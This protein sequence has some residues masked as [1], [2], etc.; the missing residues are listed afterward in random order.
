MLYWDHYF[1]W[2]LFSS[3]RSLL[4]AKAT[5]I[6]LE[7]C[8]LVIF[9]IWG[10]CFYL[11]SVFFS[12]SCF[13]YFQDCDS[14]EP[15]DSSYYWPF[16]GTIIFLWCSRM[17]AWFPFSFLILI[18]IVSWFLH[19]ILCLFHWDQSVLLMNLFHSRKGFASWLDSN[20]SWLDSVISDSVEGV[21]SFS[22]SI[23]VGLVLSGMAM[24]LLRWLISLL[25]VGVLCFSACVP[26]LGTIDI[27]MGVA[28][29]HPSLP[30]FSLWCFGHPEG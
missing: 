5:P 7:Y 1:M 15:H 19:V 14:L 11:C 12:G 24:W 2:R 13:L 16:C 10:H 4:M 18:G 9:F 23:L 26:R 20:C 28:R 22:F 25:A 17:L 30:H 3:T 27:S 8:P 21:I 29:L 6:L